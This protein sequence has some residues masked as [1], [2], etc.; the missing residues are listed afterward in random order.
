MRILILMGSPRHNGNTAEL[1]KPFI[2]RLQELGAETDYVTLHDKKIKPCLACYSCQDI[3]GEY[4]CI[5]KDDMQ[6]IVQHIIQADCIILATPIYSWYCTSEMKVLLDRHYGL[7]KFYGSANGSLW[8]GKCVGIIA[9][10][11][12]EGD[13][14]TGPFE[15]GVERLCKHSAL[16][17][18]G[19]YSVCDEDNIASF[20]TE[21]A[22]SGARAFADRVIQLTADKLTQT[23]EI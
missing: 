3:Q 23:H 19:M 9:T 20:Q 10:H 17:Y 4:G 5:Q 8:A 6:E 7:N 14:A 22:V 15:T 18:L 11:G 16:N 12:Y 21:S 2:Q 13:Y 1:C